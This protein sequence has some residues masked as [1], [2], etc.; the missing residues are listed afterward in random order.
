MGIRVTCPQGH[1][2][3]V[4]SHLAGKKGRCPHCDSV[5]VIPQPSPD[6]EPDSDAP[7]TAFDQIDIEQLTRESQ[8]PR[9]SAS[10]A[11]VGVPQSSASVAGA[12]GAGS[13][14]RSAEPPDDITSDP[15]AV[16]YVRRISGEQYGPAQSMLFW[17]W[18]QEGRVPPD[19]Y[20]WKQGWL[21]WKSAKDWFAKCAEKKSRIAVA[22]KLLS[23][24]PAAA[25]APVVPSPL[26]SRHPTAAPAAS[27]AAA[28]ASPLPTAPSPL[29][30]AATRAVRRRKNNDI[31][32]MVIVFL[33]LA[34]LAS[35]TGAVIVVY[36]SIQSA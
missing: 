18:V 34:L 35:L 32:A 23:A 16:W 4:K 6:D 1:I 5:I 3:K 13:P 27:P 15:T 29:T 22:D 9:R 12:P 31:T 17:Q 7:R 20:V 10:S 8:E 19:S 24:Q 14:T 25:P 33:L 11:P 2:L 26:A 30:A 21:E 28:S 36:Q